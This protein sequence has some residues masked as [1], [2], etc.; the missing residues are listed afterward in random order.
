MPDF[1]L[2]AL[3]RPHMSVGAT[4]AHTL[5]GIKAAGFDY[6]GLNQRQEVAPGQM[7]VPEGAPPQR[8]REV[9]QILADAGLT[10]VIMF[11][12]R[13]GD[14]G[15]ETLESYYRDLD[16]CQALG[17]TRLL[18]W[19]P[20]PYR[21]GLTVR[22]LRREWQELTARFFAGMTPLARAAEQT[23]VLVVL[24]PHL[25]LTAAAWEL[26][27]TLERIGSPAV[28]A[29]YD[30]GN[31]H[32]YE[33]LEPEEDIKEIAGQT[34]AL[35]VKD[36]RGPRG[37]NDFPTPGDGDIDHAAIFRTLAGAG[38]SGPCVVELVNGSTVE[39]VD[40]ELAR[41][42]RYLKDI[43]ASLAQA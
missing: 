28:R 36:H 30:A 7:L 41:A 6:I 5:R 25:G 2:G 35:C 33:G 16:V 39:E 10:P 23:S 24:K 11:A 15:P 17:I 37:N 38:F 42:A 34:V 40:R 27:D 13:G 19:G 1:Q 3:T 32:Y 12:R 18:M 43:V 9:R 21:K 26:A 20:S 22:R 8:L 14:I 29:C 4:F 31:V